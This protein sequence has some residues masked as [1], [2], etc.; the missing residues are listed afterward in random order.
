MLASLGVGHSERK[1]ISLS[2]MNTCESIHDKLTDQ[3]EK[4]IFVSEDFHAE[5]DHAQGT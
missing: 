3:N 5:E 4:K 2:T 1:Y